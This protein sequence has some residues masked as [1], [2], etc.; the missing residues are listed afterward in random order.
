MVKDAEAPAWV[1]VKACPPMVS[2]AVRDALPVL[3]ATL[4]DTDP[5]PVPLAPAVTASQEALPAAVQPQFEAAVTDTLPVP[6][7]AA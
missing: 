3:A 4:K 7:E 5:G 6:P 2:A 1:T